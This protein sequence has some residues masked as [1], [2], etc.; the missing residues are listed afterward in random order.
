M[1]VHYLEQSNIK[2][3]KLPKK[4]VVDPLHF[5]LINKDFW[6]DANHCRILSAALMLMN[7]AWLLLAHNKA[8]VPVQV[9]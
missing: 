5:S 1:L 2:L 3:K 8:G 7:D 9:K 4:T 6:K